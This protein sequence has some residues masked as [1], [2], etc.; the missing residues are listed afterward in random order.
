MEPGILEFRLS[1]K[2]PE[3]GGVAVGGAARWKKGDAIAV[4]HLPHRPGFTSISAAEARTIMSVGSEPAGSRVLRC[5]ETWERRKRDA[6][7]HQAH[8]LLVARLWGLLA[9]RHNCG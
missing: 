4:A 6:P 9:T 5:R 1:A 2:K 7:G 8:P 3:A